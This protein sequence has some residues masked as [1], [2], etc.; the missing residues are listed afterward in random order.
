MPFDLTTAKPVA[1]QK[2]GGFDLSTARPVNAAPVSGA[3]A[4]PGASPEQLASA[5]ASMP[6]APEQEDNLLG[7]IVGPVDAGLGMLSGMVSPLVAVPGGFIKSAYDEKVNGV[8]R[9]PEENA[10]AIRDRLQYKPATATGRRILET[11]GEAAPVLEALPGMGNDLANL[12]RAAGPAVRAGAD[13][14]NAGGAKLSQMAK[15][16]PLAPRIDPTT[17]SLAKAAQE[18]Y[19]IPLRPDQLY[20]NRLSRM[21]GEASEKVPLSGAKTDV[22]QEAFNKAVIRTIGG[23]ETAGRLTPDV[24]DKAMR[25]SGQKIGNIAARH[26]LPLDEKL[27]GA[28]DSHIASAAKYE[29][30]DV[31][32]AVNSYITDLRSKAV[33]GVIPGEAVRKLNTAITNKM[34]TTSNGDLKFALGELQDDIQNAVQK[35]LSGE[36]LSAWRGARQQYAYGKTIEPLVAK[37]ATG[38][39]SP[40][41]LMGRTTANNAGKARMARG[42]GGD[43]GELAR[44]GQRFLKEPA[45]SGT[46]ERSLVYGALGGGAVMEPTTAAG[47]FSLANLYNRTGPVVARKLSG[48]RTPAQTTLANMVGGGE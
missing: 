17:A 21:A 23:D 25:T 8:V 31:G 32:K 20:D 13:V 14:A 48:A 29:T 15:S 26:P 6:A 34:R 9:S 37:S 33:D 12:S 39:I 46:A 11:V 4:I 3:A 10:A 28:L 22:R 38:D 36:D 42:A 18:K 30:A 5:R 19:G 47:V 35:N 40:A 27:T 7:K 24:F 1:P 41:G 16:V 45:S 44:I 2:T 43:L